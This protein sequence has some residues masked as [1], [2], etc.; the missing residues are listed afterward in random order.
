MADCQVRLSNDTPIVSSDINIRGIQVDWRLQ[1]R[2]ALVDEFGLTAELIHTL[3]TSSVLPSV[4]NMQKQN[5]ACRVVLVLDGD[6]FELP[7]MT[8]F[9]SQERLAHMDV[10]NNQD[11]VDVLILDDDCLLDD[12]SY[13]ICLAA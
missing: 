7:L 2:K 6:Q 11:I 13:A 9:L 12:E 10:G 8:R 1:Q 4:T 3:N 5:L